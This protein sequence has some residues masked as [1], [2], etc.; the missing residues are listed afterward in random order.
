MGRPGAAQ[1]AQNAPFA[2]VEADLGQRLV[3]RP[4]EPSRQPDDPVDDPLDRE[5]DVR[6]IERI[7]EVVDVIALELWARHELTGTLDEPSPRD[8]LAHATGAKESLRAA[9]AAARAGRPQPATHSREE[10]FAANAT[11]EFASIQDDAERVT[12]ALVAEVELL[13]AD[14]LGD[15]P[16]SIEGEAVADEILQQAVPTRSRTSSTARAARP[17]GR[18]KS[19][20]RSSFLASLHRLGPLQRTRV[21][22]PTSLSLRALAGRDDEALRHVMDAVRARPTLLEHARTDPISRRMHAAESGRRG[23]VSRAPRLVIYVRVDGRDRQLSSPMSIASFRRLRV[24]RRGIRRAR[25]RAPRPPR[26]GQRM[27]VDASRRRRTAF[28]PR[29]HRAALFAPRSGDVSTR[30]RTA[31]TC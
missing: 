17:C 11:R 10:L 31:M 20:P 1:R 12:P 14:A 26:H 7:E 22:V 5:V 2:V 9:L 24:R 18:G 13:D 23:R 15:C 27:H 16:D 25:E 30:C 6:Q 21:A 3:E 8:L 19:P 4:P 28:R 29:A